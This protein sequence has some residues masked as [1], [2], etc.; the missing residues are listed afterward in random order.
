VVLGF[1]VVLQSFEDF[2]DA[3]LHNRFGFWAKALMQTVGQK[4]ANRNGTVPHEAA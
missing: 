2:L 3:G 1:G 4:G